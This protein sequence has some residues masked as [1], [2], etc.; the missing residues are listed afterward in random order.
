[1]LARMWT[2]IPFDWRP[3][4]AI[5]LR[6]EAVSVA[7]SVGRV[8]PKGEDAE[9]ARA[10][11]GCVSRWFPSKPSTT[12]RRQRFPRTKGS[13][14]ASEVRPFGDS[15]NKWVPG[16]RTHPTLSR[17][18]QDLCFAAI[19]D[20]EARPLAGPERRGGVRIQGRFA[21]RG[22]DL[23]HRVPRQTRRRKDEECGKNVARVPKWSRCPA[24]AFAVA[25]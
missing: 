3:S 4:A 17:S 2:R 12:G 20:Q 15:R 11:D 6:A 19:V 8:L 23:Q 18:F 9:N 14:V 24:A 21:R 16:A 22:R 25:W 7:T 1:M 10:L 13:P 5:R